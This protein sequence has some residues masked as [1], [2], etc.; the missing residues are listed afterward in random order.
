MA[1]R[2]MCAVSCIST[3]NVDCPRR[4]WSV[5]PTRVK[6][7]STRPTLASRAGTKLPI[8]A[9][10]TM[11]AV[12]RRKVDLP[13]MLGPVRICSRGAVA[14]QAQV[15]GHEG[16]GEHALHHRVAALDVDDLVL[17]AD[18]GLDVAVAAGRLG[19]GGQDVEGG[20]GLRRLLDPARGRGDPGAQGLE[21]LRLALQDPLVGAQDLLLVLLQLRG[22]EALAAHHGLLA[23]VVLGH[24]RRGWPW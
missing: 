3:M 7:R 1:W 10:I 12:W 15:V 11:S 6:I 2:R 18:A 23:V 5:A 19:Q 22:D 21:D 16:L 13:P 4:I 9:R 14:A 20:R 17:A 24:Q 8:W